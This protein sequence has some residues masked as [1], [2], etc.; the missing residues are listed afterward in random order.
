M[1]QIIIATNDKGHFSELY[2]SLSAQGDVSI[3]WAESE[4]DVLN[5]AE[6][7]SPH[8]IIIDEALGQT[9][10][11]DMARKVV[12]VNALVNIAL[13]STLSEADFH[14]AAEGLGILSRLPLNPGEAHAKMLIGKLEK[15]LPGI[16]A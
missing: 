6:K 15:V 12:L 3:R 8:L 4:D 2:D 1:I 16:S 13:V 5:C 14:E 9:E 11:L 10:G 7:I